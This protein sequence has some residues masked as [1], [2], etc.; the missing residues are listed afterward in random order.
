MKK[1]NVLFAAMLIMASLGLNAQVAINTN[2]SSANGSAMLDVQSTTKGFLPPRMT[3]AQIGAIASPADG[4]L[5]YNTTDGKLYIYVSASSVW[6]DVTF[7]I[8]TISPPFVCGSTLTP[9]LSDF[10]KKK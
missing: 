3:T 4:L 8:G 10:N 6:K 1:L 9:N 2:G 7:G 5:V